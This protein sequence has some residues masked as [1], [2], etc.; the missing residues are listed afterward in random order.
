MIRLEIKRLAKETRKRMKNKGGKQLGAEYR[1][2][3]IGVKRSLVFVFRVSLVVQV[4]L[5]SVATV[6]FGFFSV[7]RRLFCYRECSNRHNNTSN[8]GKHCPTLYL[9]DKKR[10]IQIHAANLEIL[11]E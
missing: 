4:C 5:G 2:N 7:F 3:K 9:S 10:F 11:K 6:W 8:D 1:D